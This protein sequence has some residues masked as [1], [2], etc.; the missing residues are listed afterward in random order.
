MK[1]RKFVILI[2]IFVLAASACM[3]FADRGLDEQ[4]IQGE[5]APGTP[6][7]WRLYGPDD[8][9][10]AYDFYGGL[11]EK[12]KHGGS[13]SASVLAIEVSRNDQARLTLRFLADLYRGQRV[14]FSGFLKTNRVN[15]WAGL[16]VRVDTED[17][18]SYVFDDMED[19]PVSGTTE[20]ARYE[21][22]LDVP[23]DAATIYMGAQLFGRG[24][25]WVD[26]CAFEIV[27]DEVPITNDDRLLGGHK[28]RYSIPDFLANKPENLDFEE[29]LEGP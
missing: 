5:I 18:Q 25:I 23:D 12:I 13:A 3:K 20:W 21:V 9:R 6:A 16:W 29:G 11:D 15:E 4:S 26:D 1:Q 28:R 14:R 24:Q 2:S 19:R 27:G 8:G 10:P 17:K 22:V 7:G